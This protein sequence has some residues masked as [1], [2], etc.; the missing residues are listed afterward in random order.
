MNTSLIFSSHPL[1]I[2]LE[3]D[4]MSELVLFTDIHGL[5]VWIIFA[6]IE[7]ARESTF[8]FILVMKLEDAIVKEGCQSLGKVI[9]TSVD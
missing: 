5:R 2:Q 8:E 9:E 7:N 3:M 4:Q 6:F 1:E